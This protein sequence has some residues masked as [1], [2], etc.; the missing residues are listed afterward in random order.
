MKVNIGKNTLGDSDKMSLNLR[1]YGRSTHD[2]SYAWRSTMGVGTLVPCMK[3]LGLPGDTFKIDINTKVLTDPTIG[4]LYGSYK[5]QI[6]IFS[7][8]IRLYQAMLHNNALNIGLDMKTVKLPQVELSKNREYNPSSLLAYLGIRGTNDGNQ[9]HN[10]VP[11]LAYYDIYKNYYI[12]KQEKNAYIIGPGVAYIKTDI[13]VGKGIVLTS[14]DCTTYTT[15]ENQL[16]VVYQ[17]SKAF[18]PTETD[19]KNSIR[20]TKLEL[21]NKNGQKENDII[22]KINQAGASHKIT[23]SGAY[24]TV[25]WTQSTKKVVATN[26]NSTCA[27]ELQNLTI[28]GVLAYKEKG[29]STKLVKNEDFDETRE[30]ILSKGR[31]QYIVNK[32]NI[33]YLNEIE[34]NAAAPLGGLA[35][36]THLSDLFNNWVNQEWVEGENGIANVT[37][38]DTSSGKFTMDTLNLAKKVYEMLNRI[39]VSGGSYKDWIETVYTSDYYFRAETP[40]YEGGLSSEIEFDEVVSNSSSTSEGVEQPLGTIAGRGVDTMKKGGDITIKVNEPSYIIGI[41]SITPRVDYSQGNDWDDKLS[42]MDELHKPQLDGIGYQDLL[43]TQMHYAAKEGTA[44]GKQPAWINYM[45][46]VNKTY[47]EFAANQPQS[48]MVLNKIYGVKGDGELIGATTYINPL[49]YTYIFAENSV[50]GQNFKVQI[51]FQVEARRVMSAKQIP[52][53]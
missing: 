12:N 47:G 52:N 16:Y 40:V 32:S 22:I 31:T 20:E 7:C 37:A 43:C 28:I 44:L 1:E 3:M 38:V 21:N 29:I 5:L 53:V 2:L 14:T 8:P 39:A 6:D 23:D 9:L 33:K 24:Y 27:T 17:L 10:A 25:E 41:V 13:K 49:D 4:A 15:S 11:L 18:F 35:I 45:T 34:I 30:E 19:V 36:K 46:N 48:F 42:N 26:I 50:T 51:G